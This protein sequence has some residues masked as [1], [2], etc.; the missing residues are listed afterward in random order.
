[1]SDDIPTLTLQVLKQIRDDIRD[2]R[3]EAVESNRRLESDARFLNKQKGREGEALVEPL[4]TD[5]D[6]VRA[7][8]HFHSVP[9]RQQVNVAPGM[10]VSFLDAGHVLSPTCALQ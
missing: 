8:E 4:Y 7:I 1:M 9:Y 10:R 3:G 6:V 2:L 5:D